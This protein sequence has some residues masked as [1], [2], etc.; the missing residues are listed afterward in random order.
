VK[1][2]WGWASDDAQVY[3][4]VP[5]RGSRGGFLDRKPLFYSPRWATASISCWRPE[6]VG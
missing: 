2:S 6:L 5:Y 3:L 1:L 4:S